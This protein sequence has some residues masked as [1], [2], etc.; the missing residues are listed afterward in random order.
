MNAVDTVTGAPTEEVTAEVGAVA[1]IFSSLMRSFIKTRNQMLAEAANDVEW[2]AQIVLKCL[3]IE[4]SLRSGAL[5][6]LINSDPSTVSRQVAGLVKEGYIERR[7][8]PIDGRANLLLLTPKAD[9]LVRELDAARDRN[10]ARMLAE[11]NERD[12]R[13]FAALLERFTEDYNK[14]KREWLPGPA[15]VRLTPAEGN[16]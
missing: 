7:A 3:A 16:D 5:A 9:E 11:W 15:D 1:D 14:I 4:G 6:E 12:L 10:F 2:S 8:D 13:R